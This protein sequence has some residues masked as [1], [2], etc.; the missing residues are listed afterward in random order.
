M[1]NTATQTFVSETL[2][3]FQSEHDRLPIWSEVTQSP[4]MKQ[5]NVVVHN[6]KV[7]TLQNICLPLDK[8]G[9]THL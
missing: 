3:N 5:S 9:L 4:Q 1:Q 2:G 7:Q 6:P 8:W